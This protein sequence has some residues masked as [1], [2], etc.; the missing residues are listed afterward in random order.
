[1][2]IIITKQ[3]AIASVSNRS[4]IEEAVISNYF[5]MRGSN[6]WEGTSSGAHWLLDG[7]VAVRRSRW[8]QTMTEY[9]DRNC[10]EANRLRTVTT[11]L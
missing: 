1:M 11:G 2:G 7:N 6:R 5:R 3:K 8:D 10:A 9:I 4:E